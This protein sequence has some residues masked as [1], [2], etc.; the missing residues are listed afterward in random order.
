M[1]L[2]NF[3][4]YGISM[5][6]SNGLMPYKAFNPKANA[7]RKYEL[8]LKQIKKQLAMDSRRGRG[9][10]M[11]SMSTHA[12]IGFP[13]QLFTRLDPNIIDVLFSVL[14]ASQVLPQKKEGDWT[15]D[16]VSFIVQ[17]N[18][19]SV[20]PYNDFADGTT[21]DINYNFPVRQAFRYQTSIEYGNLEAAK[22]DLAG[23]NF[24]ASK[25][26]AAA[27]IMARQE[28]NFYLFG[29]QGL[30]NYGLFNDPNLNAPISPITQQVNGAGK[31][32][33]EDKAKSTDVALLIY[34]D[35]VELFTELSKNNGGLIDDNS[36]LILVLSNH[37]SPYLKRAS[38]FNVS[39]YDMI[40]KAYPNMRIVTLPEC[41]QADGEKLIMLAT[42]VG[43]QDTGYTAFCEKFN[44]GPVIPG[45]SSFSQKVQASTLGS[46]ILRPSAIAMMNGI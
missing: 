43:G 35:I 29:V 13:V 26:T 15:T 28:N 41:S 11:D 38:Q 1:N 14:N 31:T 25:Q 8:D 34:S 45:H 46:V 24:V 27:N 16:N 17:E 33:W 20:S 40:M 7:G 5:A 36:E 18:V 4:E 9:M 3:K 6:G 44:V 12:N 22:A 19:G 39:V 21:S 37:M 23:V 10:A 30:K 2:E 42:S 32:K